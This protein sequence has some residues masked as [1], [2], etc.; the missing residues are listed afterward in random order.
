MEEKG[1]D[2]GGDGPVMCNKLQMRSAPSARGCA[3]R[4][5]QPVPDYQNSQVRPSSKTELARRLDRG[6]GRLGQF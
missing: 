4:Q 2:L 3:S 1:K 5:A 6:W